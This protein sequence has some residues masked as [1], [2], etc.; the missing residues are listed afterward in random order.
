MFKDELI[1]DKPITIP[2]LKGTMGGRNYYLFS[3][4]PNTLLKIGF[5]LHRTKVNDSMAPTY[6][7]LL[8]PK[9]LKGITKF[10]D[11]GGFFPN[12][13]ILN[14][15]DP[16]EHIKVTFD[17]IHKEEDSDAEFGLL[18]IPNAYGIAY[19]IDGQHRVYGYSNSHHKNDHTIPVVA[20]QNM[21]SE[22]KMAHSSNLMTMQ[23]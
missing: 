11:D 14:F 8:V 19:I 13:I 23:L 15:A 18:N 4:E 16:N 12:S 3:I 22:E 1:S 10:I 5:V 21:E 9:R 2:S 20:F 17:P 6:Q 7:R